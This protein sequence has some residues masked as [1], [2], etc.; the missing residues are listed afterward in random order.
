MAGWTSQVKQTFSDF[1]DD[2]CT[3]VTAALVGE[4]ARVGRAAGGRQSAR[5]AAPAGTPRRA[6]P[7]KAVQR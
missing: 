5:R 2:H 7:S 6:I 3:R 1:L 4:A